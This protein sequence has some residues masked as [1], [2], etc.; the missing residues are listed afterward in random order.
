MFDDYN[1]NQLFMEAIFEITT[2]SRIVYAMYHKDDDVTEDTVIK[3]SNRAGKHKPHDRVNMV[4]D[5]AKHGHGHLPCKWNSDKAYNQQSLEAARKRSLRH[6]DIFDDI[7]MEEAAEYAAMEEEAWRL[8]D[9]EEEVERI[10]DSLYSAASAYRF[11]MDA[12][13]NL[14]V[15]MSRDA[16]RLQE[17][18]DIIRSIRR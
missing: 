17:L 15:A 4:K 9:A 8:H 16:T 13:E 1:N 11:H 7:T 14:N 12:I 3:K 5:K 2:P 10:L 6:D 18:N